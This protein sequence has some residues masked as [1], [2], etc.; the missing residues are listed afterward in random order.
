MG[1]LREECGVF[2]IYGK[3]NQEVAAT[4]YYGLFALQ[5]RGQESCGIAVC[6]DGVIAAHKDLG[7]V[8]EVFTPE[9]LARLGQGN[10][11]V[12][13]VRYGTTGVTDRNNA[14]PIVVNH[15]KGSLALVHNGN[16]VNSYALREELEL[17]GSIF[18]S[19]SDT[20][21]ISYVIT[22][23]RLSASS[24]EEAVDRAMDKLQGAYSL[25]VM[26]ATKLMAVRDPRGFRPLCYGGPPTA[27]T[28]SLP[29]A[30][31]W[32]PPVRPSSGMW[33]L[34]RLWCLMGTR[35]APS[36]PTAAR[37]TGACVSLNTST[38]PGRTR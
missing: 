4:S 19:T 32:T 2:G 10:M 30:A 11:A 3:E 38:L 17:T 6:N 36:A 15:C 22:K 24:I 34:G 23:E 8:E 13:H 25:V 27:R 7:L 14:Q 20:E 21:V 1:K 28:S 16:L 26:S 18:H 31:P 35:C 12:G 29:R 33:S 5:H 37:R 9:V